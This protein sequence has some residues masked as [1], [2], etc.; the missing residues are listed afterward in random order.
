MKPTL[1]GLLVGLVFG[2]VI[3]QWGRLAKL[4]LVV[5][6]LAPPLPSPIPSS[7]SSSPFS[8]SPF[9]SSLPQLTLAQP[10]P[11]ATMKP[12]L[13]FCWVPSRHASSP[14]ME[15]IVNTWLSTCDKFIFTATQANPK[16]NVVK[17]DYPTDKQ[18]WNMIHPAWSYVEKHYGED[19]DW[20]VKLDDDSYFSAPNFKFLVRNY[21]PEGYYYLGHQMHEV[22]KR[23]DDLQAWFNLGAGHALSRASLRRMALHLPNSDNPNRVPK[24]QQCPQVYTW[25]EDVKLGEC[26][27]KAGGIGHPNNTRDA[28][29]RENFMAFLPESNFLTVRRP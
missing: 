21:D 29:G 22:S 11:L 8:S 9:S 4:Q 16:L 25:A 6:F 12:P 10:S 27:Y 7:L 15:K 28:W 1:L 2:L 19:Y 5:P 17:I 20:F 13:V 26:L 14:L 23:A 24:G 18:L 3:H